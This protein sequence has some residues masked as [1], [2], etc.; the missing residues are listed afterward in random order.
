MSRTMSFISRSINV[1][2]RSPCDEAIH[3]SFALRDGLL[4]RFA[5]RSDVEG[6]SLAALALFHTGIERIARGVTDQI[7]AEDRDRQQQ[8]RPEDQRGFDLK[9]GAALGHDV[10]PGRC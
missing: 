5:P 1:I 4:R 8:A 3:S 10:A 6:V 7:D 2:A 9:I